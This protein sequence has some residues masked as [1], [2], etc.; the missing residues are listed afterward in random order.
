MC[1]RFLRR[2]RA[3]RRRRLSAAISGRLWSA[4]I[5]DRMRAYGVS[6]EEAITAVNQSSAVQPSG[7]VRTGDLT[8]FASTNATIGGNLP[9]LMDAP[10]RAG[11]APSIY[12]RDIGVVENG[13]TS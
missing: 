9:E 11:A 6:P 2:C 7:N 3:F 10:V 1:G 12:L 8:R 5:P 13:P 4:S